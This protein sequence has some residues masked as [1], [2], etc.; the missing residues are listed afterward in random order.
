MK[1]KRRTENDF[2]AC[3]LFKFNNLNWSHMKC[4][5][6]LHTLIDVL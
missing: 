6:Y 2:E 1:K 4:N 5:L 3:F